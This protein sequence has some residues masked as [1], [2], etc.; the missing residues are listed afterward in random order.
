MSELRIA[1]VGFAV[2]GVVS[3]RSVR[4]GV[5]GNHSDSLL[6]GT[7]QAVEPAGNPSA[8]LTSNSKM[9]S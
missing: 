4:E 9:P 3:V 5:G 7:N 6:N 8:V 1:H 2:T